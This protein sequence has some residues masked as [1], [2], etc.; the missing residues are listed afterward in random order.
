MTKTSYWRGLLGQHPDTKGH[1]G[2]GARKGS[3]RGKKNVGTGTDNEVE[4]KIRGE[5][6]VLVLSE[7]EREK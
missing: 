7:E 5:R 3:K 4:L 2:I 6:R 1:L